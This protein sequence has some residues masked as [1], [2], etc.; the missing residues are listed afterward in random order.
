MAAVLRVIEDPTEK[1]ASGAEACRDVQK[2][3]ADLEH[4]EQLAWRP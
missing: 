1:V 2:R 4:E 3:H